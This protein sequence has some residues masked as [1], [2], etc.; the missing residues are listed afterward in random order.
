MAAF[1][2][3]RLDMTAWAM[4]YLGIVQKVPN[5]MPVG[6]TGALP[7]SLQR[8][9]EAHG[10]TVH[11][12]SRVAEIVLSHGRATAVALESGRVVRA[13]KGIISTANPVITLNELLPAADGIRNVEDA[14]FF[15][16]SQFEIVW[17]YRFL[18]RDLNDLLSK[19]RLLETR[20]QGVLKN[21]T[22]AVR[23]LLALGCAE[24]P[25]GV[26]PLRAA[27]V[28]PA[29]PS[30]PGRHPTG[31]RPACCRSPRPPPQGGS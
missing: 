5:A 23:A 13:R 14:W 10:G 18:Y 8:Y 29:A 19:N 15:L 27:P 9:L 22:R 2:Q 4:I 30:P 24:R 11:T 26:D 3:M 17:Q 31:R 21:K 6:G 7:A 1:S 25:Q 20:F 16:H 28:R 12:N